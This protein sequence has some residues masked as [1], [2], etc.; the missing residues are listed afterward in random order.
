M[1]RGFK[2]SVIIVI[3]IEITLQS[4]HDTEHCDE[5]YVG[6]NLERATGSMKINCE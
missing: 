3:S 4:V 5:A 2:V 6:L 1:I